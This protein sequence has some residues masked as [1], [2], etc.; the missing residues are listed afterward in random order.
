MAMT[1]ASYRHMAKEWQRRARVARDAGG[2]A[3][4]GGEVYANRERAVWISY[5]ARGKA[6]FNN[7]VGSDICAVEIGRLAPGTSGV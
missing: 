7:L 3:V 6:T 2:E 1:C 5:A 4:S